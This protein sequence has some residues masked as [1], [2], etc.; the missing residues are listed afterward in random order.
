[1]GGGGQFFLFCHTCGFG[2]WETNQ[3]Q[4]TIGFGYLEKKI[5]INE[6]SVLSISKNLKE[7]P[8]FMKEPMVFQLVI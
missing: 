7:S 4:R 6:P 5:R 2:Y 3:N 8:N 1:M